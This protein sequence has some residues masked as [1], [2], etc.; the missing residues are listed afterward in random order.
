MAFAI[1][2]GLTMVVT[3]FSEATTT[4]RGEA[5]RSFDNSMLDGTDAPKRVWEFTHYPVSEAYAATLRTLGT[6]IRTFSGDCLGGASTTVK[7][8]ITRQEYV[9]SIVGNKE[10]YSAHYVVF[11]F[12]LEEA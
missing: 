12:A 6:G 5:V 11:T 8:R 2:S 4:Y 9:P 1:L 7:V 10:D 3:S